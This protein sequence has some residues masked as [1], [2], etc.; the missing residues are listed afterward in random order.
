MADE[1]NYRQGRPGDKPVKYKDTT[2]DGSWSEEIASDLYGWNA[3]TLTWVK[4]PVDNST[5]GLKVFDVGGGVV[6]VSMSGTQ[7]VSQA[8]SFNVI[9]GTNPWNVDVISFSNT[10][11]LNV[12]LASQSNGVVSIDLAS[13]SNT[14]TV[15]ENVASIGGS[16]ANPTTAK[17]TQAAGFLGV[18]LATDGGRT[19]VTLWVDDVGGISTE[20]LATMNITKGGLSQATSTTYPITAGKTFRI[21]DFVMSTRANVASSQAARA[22]VRQGNSA[23]SS[24]L[25]SLQAAVVSGVL[26]SVGINEADII[27][28]AIEVPGGASLAISHV[29]TAILSNTF[30][31][32]LIGYEF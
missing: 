23:L 30:S 22:R 28:G 26:N 13:Y 11:T 12:N 21:C 32:C 14:K 27:Q 16:A 19:P 4:V 25:I 10:K 17:G 20:A 7:L 18:Q 24:V 8:G 29:E 9:Q 2:A 31:C 1:I 3:T 15:N 6:S 5:G